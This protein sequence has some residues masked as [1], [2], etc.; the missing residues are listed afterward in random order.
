MKNYKQIITK[1]SRKFGVTIRL[2][3]RLRLSNTKVFVWEESCL[4]P[5]RLVPPNYLAHC[6]P[7]FALV[8]FLLFYLFIYLCLLLKFGPTNCVCV[9]VCVQSKG[10]E[11]HGHTENGICTQTCFIYCCLSLICFEFIFPIQL[12]LIYLLKRFL[13]ICP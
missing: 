13:G 9:S 11:N 4:Y 8:N 12:R 3:W 2:G 10:K 1:N 5:H 7:L 6:R